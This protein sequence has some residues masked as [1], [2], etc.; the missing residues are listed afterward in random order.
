MPDWTF[1]EMVRDTIATHGLR[2]AVAYYYKK[3]PA[4]EAR[5]FLR[6]ALAG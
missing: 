4:W 3:L 1:T 2:W 5:F 6:A